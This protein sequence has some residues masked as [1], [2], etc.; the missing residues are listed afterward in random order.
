[1]RQEEHNCGIKPNEYQSP[2][3]R[4]DPTATWVAPRDKWLH[5]SHDKVNRA[6]AYFWRQRG[7]AAN[8]GSFHNPTG[9]M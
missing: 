6:S 2:E 9:A 8:I 7:I 3:D 1:M 5:K 4:V